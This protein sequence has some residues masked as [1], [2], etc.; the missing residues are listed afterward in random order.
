MNS[1]ACM[2]YA[3]LLECDKIYYIFCIPIMRIRKCLVKV[4]AIYLI[5]FGIIQIF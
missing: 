1:I 3:F 4:I 2:F 5:C